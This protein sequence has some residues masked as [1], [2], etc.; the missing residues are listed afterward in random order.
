MTNEVELESSSDAPTFALVVVD[1]LADA[2][3]LPAALTGEEN[4]TRTTTE[5]ARVEGGRDREGDRRAA[6]VPVWSAAGGW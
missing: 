1:V 4:S 2:D 5:T 6:L 3:A